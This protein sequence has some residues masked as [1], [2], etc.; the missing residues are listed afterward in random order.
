MANKKNPRA[1]KGNP[2]K[3]SVSGAGAIIFAKHIPSAP[4]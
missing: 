2:I 1:K 3:T 4:Y